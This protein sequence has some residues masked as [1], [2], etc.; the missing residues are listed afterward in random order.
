[1]VSVTPFGLLLADG[2]TICDASIAQDLQENGGTL[3][4]IRCPTSR[5]AERACLKALQTSR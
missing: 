4:P 5:L 1:M 2:A 3:S